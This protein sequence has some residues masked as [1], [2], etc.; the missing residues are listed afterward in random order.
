MILAITYGDEKYY[1]MKRVNQFTAKILGK[2]DR[3]HAYG[4]EDIGDE[5]K[6]ENGHIFSQGRLG[7]YCIWKPYVIL[8]ALDTIQEGD[9]CMYLDSGAYYISDLHALQ[10][11]LEKDNVDFLFSSSLLP[12][13]HWTKRDAF[14]LMG[15]DNENI[16]NS[17]Q[18]EATFLFFRKTKES[19][20]FVEEWLRLMSDARLSTDLD[21]QCGFE[22]YEGFREHRHDQSVMSLLAK[23]KGYIPYKSVSDS[24]EYR[25]LIRFN[26]GQYYGYT[27]AE[28]LNSAVDEWNSEGYKKSDYG[29][30]VISTRMKNEKLYK[31]IPRF[32]KASLRALIRTDLIGRAKEKS[33]KEHCMILAV[34]Y[35][36]DKFKLMKKVNEFTA[37][38]WGGQ[39]K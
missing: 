13:K 5:F 30:I 38:K 39:M 26:D 22:N 21:N 17:R 25:K 37:K 28:L 33:V 24:S 12:E 10:K 3:V 14:I 35:G 34:T 4:P 7:G 23:K 32:I 9:Y 31:W 16:V 2:A 18:I 27:R 11:Q 29:R 36:D 1:Y 8:K 15:C 19:V 6:A 20:A